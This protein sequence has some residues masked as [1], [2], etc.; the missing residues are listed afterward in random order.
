V[1][2]SNHLVAVVDPMPFWRPSSFDAMATFVD[3]PLTVAWPEN[4][5]VAVHVT[6]ECVCAIEGDVYEPRGPA[7]AEHFAAAYPRRG[8]RVLEGLRGDCWML[9]WDRR[10]QGGVVACDQLGGHAPYWARYGGAT[11]V[12]GE[13]RE[14]IDRLPVTPGPDETFMV[15]WLGRTMAPE[16]RSF[17]DGV[18]RLLAGHSLP[19]G[20]P[21]LQ[22]QRYWAPQYHEPSPV[23]GPDAAAE[24]RVT[25]ERA[26]RRRVADVSRVGVLLSGG[27]DSSTTLA[28]TH[29]VLESN[30][31]L[32]AYS[33]TFPGLPTADETALIDVTAS[34]YGLRSTR[35]VV[36]EAS[37]IRG[38]L[39]Y[40]EEWAVPPVTPNLF[41][42]YPLLERA[43]A[44]GTQ[45]MLAGEGGDELFGL[46]PY[47][48]ADRVRRGQW[49]SAVRL[50]REFP[51]GA[52]PRQ[53][54]K[55]LRRFGVWGALPP[56]VDRA[57]RR[58]LNPFR[59]APEW[60]TPS[61]AR[62]WMATE[63]S[64]RWKELDGARWWT[65]LVEA[66]TAGVGP[67][68]V[69]EQSRRRAASAGLRA[70]HPLVDVDVV[71][72]MLRLPP[73]LSI[74]R[75][76]SRPLLRQSTEGRLPEEVRL[77]RGK[78]SFDEI[79]H[80]CLAG[81]DLRAA[82]HLLGD[83]EA[84]VGAWVDLARMGD[85]VLSDRAATD[86]SAIWAVGLWRLIMAEC[87]LR[88]QEDPGFAHSLGQRSD[89]YSPSF[90][91]SDWSAPQAAAT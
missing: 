15:H 52:S 58:H 13:L 73:E 70:R 17:Y 87:W 2:R 54:G 74:D 46:S 32:E 41:F 26:A 65:A 23:S 3:G 24:L 47:L 50:A 78:S 27:L 48:L 53:V 69:A 28:M 19:I 45:V 49:L 88:C 79:F 55:R 34:R 75:R 91:V 86:R 35:I 38:G 80:R 18:R 43:S 10:R 81:P 14:V 68:I 82:R 8:M 6:D 61:A 59:Y 84:R 57:A 39:R 31:E 40:L 36:G 89:A 66:T 33:A 44:D 67:N 63:N 20:G 60:L 12:A 64:H 7:P 42:W 71:E 1:T 29:P 16:G 22:P 21:A 11:I 72:L 5:R 76:W 77:R 9:L 37:I 56:A 51:G 90:V 30:Q 25:L 62:R 83:P 4:G 85:A